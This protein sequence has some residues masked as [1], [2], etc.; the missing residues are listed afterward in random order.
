MKTILLNIAGALFIIVGV[1][2]FT[3]CYMI[4]DPEIEGESARTPLSAYLMTLIPVA[5]G[6][7]LIMLAHRIKKNR[8]SNDP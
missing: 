5:L 4:S 1:L 2:L 7:L 8:I 3:F 6:I